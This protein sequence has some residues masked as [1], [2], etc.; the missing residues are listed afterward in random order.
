M[1][2]LAE[3]GQRVFL[4]NDLLSW[5]KA[6]LQFALWFTV[7]PLIKRFVTGRLRNLHPEQPSAALELSLALLSRTTRIF[8]VVV[9]SYLA[10]QWLTVPAALHK[11]VQGALLLIVWLQ[12]ARW[13]SEAVRFFVDQRLRRDERAAKESAASLNILKFVGIASIWAF[14]ALL[15]LSNL[16]VD[17]TALIAGLGVGG[18]AIAL[19][20]QNVLGDLLAS[21]SI[22]LD[23]PFKVGDF[24]IIGSEMGTVEHIGIKSTRLRSLSGEQ[25][26]MSNADLLQSRVHNYGLLYERRTL[27]KLGIVYQTPRDKVAEVPQILEDA[28]R[29]QDKTRFDRAHFAAFGAFSLDYEAVYFVLDPAYGTYMDIQQAINLRIMD[30]FKR[31]GIEFAYPTQL[32]YNVELPPPAGQADSRPSSQARA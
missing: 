27:F 2:E 6:L 8:L 11:W 5:L 29:A 28:I 25:I 18:I 24:L 10:L 19:A 1:N 26:V 32:Q 3:L 16:G 22:A 31:R 12:V 21:L 9:A 30:E 14:A 23:K 7:L 15:L 20:V 4:G 17:V 13:G